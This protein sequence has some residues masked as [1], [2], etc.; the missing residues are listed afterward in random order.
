MVRLRPG[1]RA[2]CAGV[3]AKLRVAITRSQCLCTYVLRSELVRE[4]RAGAEGASTSLSRQSASEGGARE[5]FRFTSVAP[6]SRAKPLRRDEACAQHRLANLRSAGRK[7][8]SDS[9]P[10]A[11]NPA[12]HSSAT[13]R[14]ALL[15]RHLALAIWRGPGG[16]RSTPRDPGGVRAGAKAAPSVPERTT[17]NI[18]S[19]ALACRRSVPQGW[20]RLLASA[21]PD[22]GRGEVAIVRSQPG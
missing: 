15:A 10:V 22:R 8:Q 18:A 1:R 4:G 3:A 9:V 12:L 19:T 21:I 6:A 14:R 11:E 16:E 2:A 7:L 17:P 5:A 13:L 20:S